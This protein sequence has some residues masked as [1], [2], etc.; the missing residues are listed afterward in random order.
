GP[1]HT[2]S[3]AN[4][5]CSDS[6]SA[7]ENTAT[8]LMPSSRAA[9]ITRSAISPR[10]ATRIFLNMG[11]RLDLEEC[12]AVLDRLAVVDEHRN[13]SAVDLGLDLV[14]QLHRFDD[15]DRLP[16]SHLLADLDELLC[17]GG[18]RRVKSPDERR[19]HDVERF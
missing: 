13:H 12:V 17:A 18:G 14:H 3:S 1:M 8:V 10:L 19:A 7:V 2:A 9:R 16:A 5:T 6:E 4:L 15:A 11:L